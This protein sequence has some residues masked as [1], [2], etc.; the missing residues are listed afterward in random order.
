M[1]FDASSN[2]VHAV[3]FTKDMLCFTSDGV[4]ITS[5]F[6]SNMIS[7][8]YSLIFFSLKHVNIL[9]DPVVTLRGYVTLTE[10][11]CTDNRV[12]LSLKH[13]CTALSPASIAKILEESI[14]LAGFVGVGLY[15][16]IV[17]AHRSC[18]GHCQWARSPCDAKIGAL[19]KH[20]FIIT[21]CTA[22]SISSRKILMD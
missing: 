7:R 8:E 22:S 11:V 6:A 15:S 12:F 20:S 13:P 16:K 17:Q 14:A 1:L 10:K 2:N 18:S 9:L 3:L 4:K 19:K 5:F 21:M